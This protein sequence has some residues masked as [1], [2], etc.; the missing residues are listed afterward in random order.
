MRSALECLNQQVFVSH[1]HAVDKKPF[2]PRL[3]APAATSS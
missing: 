2:K 1:G 3:A